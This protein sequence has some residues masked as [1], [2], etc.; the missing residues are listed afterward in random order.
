[1]TYPGHHVSAR[2]Q[3]PPWPHSEPLSEDVEVCDAKSGAKVGHGHRVSVHGVVRARGLIAVDQV[4]HHLH[5]A[6]GSGSRSSSSS[7]W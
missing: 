1:V 6:P 3:R 7:E 2:T 5:M 4:R